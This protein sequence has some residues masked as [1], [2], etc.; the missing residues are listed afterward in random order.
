M[1]TSETGQK[2]LGFTLALFIVVSFL[3]SL[4]VSLE[5]EDGECVQRSGSLVVLFSA[6]LEILQT[7]RKKPQEASSVI[8]EGRPAL[9]AKQISKLDTFFHRFAWT[10]IVVGTFVWGYGDV[11]FTLIFR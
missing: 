3:F 7:S 6:I 9:V 5:S 10:G 11:L 2:V 8:M 4:K 1:N